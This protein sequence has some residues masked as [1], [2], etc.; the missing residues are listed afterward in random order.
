MAKYLPQT[1]ESVL[2]QDYPNIEYI[3][4]DG[5]ST[6]GSLEILERYRGRLRYF[7]EPDRGPSGRR[8]RKVSSKP[9]AR[10]SPGLNADDT[11]LPGAV[12]KGVE[13]L[14][15]HPE[16]DVVYGEGWWIDENGGEISTAIPHYP[17][18]LKHWSASVSSASPPHLFEPR[19]TGAAPWTQPLRRLSTMTCGSAWPKP[20][21][22]SKP[23]RIIWQTLECMREQKRCANVRT[24]SM[25]L[26]VC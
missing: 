23:C 20:A 17:L 1:I 16:A 2:S 11:Y 22:V 3:V 26:W 10:F 7:S 4:A 14:A 24:Y 8:R 9:A 12:T 13:Y 18:I 5:G 6:D 19:P 15:A 25:P 21:S